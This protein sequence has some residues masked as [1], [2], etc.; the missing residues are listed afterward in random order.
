MNAQ[1]LTRDRDTGQG[2]KDPTIVRSSGGAGRLLRNE[3][4]GRKLDGSLSVSA[5]EAEADFRER[6]MKDVQ[7]QVALLINEAKS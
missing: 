3:R 7:Q 4:A 6:V 1:R 5:S 2:W